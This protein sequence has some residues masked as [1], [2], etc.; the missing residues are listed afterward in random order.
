M[1][2]NQVEGI[3]KINLIVWLQASVRHWQDAA[4]RFLRP[5]VAE[6]ST[7]LQTTIQGLD[8]GS[9]GILPPPERDQPGRPATMLLA[10]WVYGAT[11]GAVVGVGEQGE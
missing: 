4:A 3:G 10:H 5:Q 6:P 9:L 1:V 11:L 8:T 7:A 2:F